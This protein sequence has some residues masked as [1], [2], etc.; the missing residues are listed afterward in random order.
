MKTFQQH[1]EHD[2]THHHLGDFDVT[3]KLNKLPPFIDKYW[4][5]SKT[6]SE[7]KLNEN[8]HSNI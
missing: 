1:Q 4:R 5:F 6:I 2:K 7:E 8:H 3:N